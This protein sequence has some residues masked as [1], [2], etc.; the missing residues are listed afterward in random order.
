[1]KKVVIIAGVLG[2]LLIGG[3]LGQVIN[4][5]ATSK[6]ELEELVQKQQITI[7]NLTEQLADVNNQLSETSTRLEALE[8][9]ENSTEGIE[10]R[11]T[12]VE[13]IIGQ[14][15][16][17]MSV[18][19]YLND[20]DYRFNKRV[21]LLEKINKVDD[22]SIQEYI[23]NLPQLISN[24]IDRKISNDSYCWSNC[25]YPIQKDSLVLDPASAN[26]GSNNYNIFDFI[27]EEKFKEHVINAY[28]EK[29]SDKVIYKNIKVY[30]LQPFNLTYKIIEIPLQ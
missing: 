26:I 12:K 3:L 16:S 30:V 6:V 8:N 24:A 15:D 25:T 28:N 13:N 11:L 20:L 29:Q 14:W 27:T 9:K 17:E 4:V 22:L 10:T 23:N 18:I 7:D 21:L 1:M 19:Q 5:N 2:I